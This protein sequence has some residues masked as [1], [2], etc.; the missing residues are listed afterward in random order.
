[1]PRRPAAAHQSCKA[2]P[3]AAF[4]PPRHTESASKS[5]A[6]SSRPS[7]L[8]SPCT[9]SLRRASA[10]SPRASRSH[11]PSSPAQTSPAHHSPAPPP[12]P[13]QANQAPQSQQPAP[14]VV[15]SSSAS[16]AHSS[17]PRPHYSTYRNAI[18][19]HPIATFGCVQTAG[20][21][22]SRDTGLNYVAVSE[23]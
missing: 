9:A 8:Q 16:F 18:R 12:P 10:P 4:V 11:T 5:S 13:T 20:R 17:G 23:A 15:S 6:H 19:Y 14:S 7:A 2:T 21:S 3:S 1:T 22:K